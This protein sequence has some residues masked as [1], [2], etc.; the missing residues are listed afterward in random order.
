[1]TSPATARHERSRVQPEQRRGA[2]WLADAIRALDL[3]QPDAA[4][5][6]EVLEM[7]GLRPPA[8]RPPAAFVAPVSGTGPSPPE[9]TVVTPPLTARE[10][11]ATHEATTGPPALHHGPETRPVIDAADRADSSAPRPIPLLGD[12]LPLPPAPSEEAASLLPPGLQRAILASLSSREAPVGEVDV[13]VIVQLL[14]ERAAIR[15]LPRRSTVTTGRGL[16]LLLDFGDGM[17]GFQRDRDEAWDAVT[18]VAGADGLE[19]LRFAGT[20]LDDPGAGP[21][22]RW[23]W[24]NYHA[25]GW[26]RPVLVISDLGTAATAQP[27]DLVVNHWIETAKMLRLAGCPV[28]ALVPAP[29]ER[30]APELKTAM[31][32]VPWDR[33]TGVRDAVAAARR[34]ARR[35]PRAEPW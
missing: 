27:R 25:P 31:G 4:T 12:V 28:T 8:P 10:V 5:T 21:G 9:P 34:A 18:T 16:Q 17:L 6:G 14:A 11:A 24:V 35:L 3:L 30:V 23:T 26:G 32:V 19:V 7:L 13:E 2:V 20:P 29:A 22:P 15:S 1:V 33:S